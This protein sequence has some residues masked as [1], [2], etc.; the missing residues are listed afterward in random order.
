MQNLSYK[1][2]GIMMI[3]RWKLENGSPDEQLDQLYALSE[4]DIF[5]D[6][7]IVGILRRNLTST[8]NEI[9]EIS[10]MRI[11]IRAKDIGSVDMLIL[12]LSK[13]QDELVRSAAIRSLSVLYGIVVREDEVRADEILSAVHRA[14][15]G[16]SELQLIQNDFTRQA[17]RSDVRFQG[18]YSGPRRP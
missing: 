17:L 2:L 13:N 11:A 5:A 14:S 4:D 16:P 15:L 6:K 10:I 7:S 3:D 12:V 8:D 9:L 1:A 18:C